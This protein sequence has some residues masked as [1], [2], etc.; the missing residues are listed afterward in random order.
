LFYFALDL[1]PNEVVAELPA[2][3]KVIEYERTGMPLLKRAS[4]SARKVRDTLSH[5]R[6]R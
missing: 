5:P 3:Y 2:G 1:R 4:E 6:S